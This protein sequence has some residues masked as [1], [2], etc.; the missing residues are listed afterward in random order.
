MF[1]IKVFILYF[2]LVTLVFASQKLKAGEDNL[3]FPATNNTQIMS[4][5]PETGNFTKEIPIINTFLD[6]GLN[7]NY[8]VYLSD[9]GQL[10]VP[11]IV[12]IGSGNKHL[13]GFVRDVNGGVNTLSAGANGGSAVSNTHFYGTVNA[14]GVSSIYSSDGV[15]YTGDAFHGH[16]GYI[17]SSHKKSNVKFLYSDAKYMIEPHTSEKLCDYG[18]TGLYVT[19]ISLSNGYEI[20]FNVN[21]TRVYDDI[22]G[23]QFYK[24]TVVYYTKISDNQRRVWTFGRNSGNGFLQNITYPDG[25]QI[26]CLLPDPI[27]TDVNGVVYTHGNLTPN[28]QFPYVN[29]SGAN[30]TQSL[31]ESFSVDSSYTNNTI[32]HMNG[33]VDKYLGYPKHYTISADPGNGT[34]KE[35]KKLDKSG[36]VVYDEVNT[37]NYTANATPYLI[38]QTITQDGVTISKK[39]ADFNAYL[40]PQT[41]T[42]TASDGKARVTKITYLELSSSATHG[43]MV[44][45]KKIQ[46][47]DSGGKVLHII[48]NKYDIEGYL[49]SSTNDGVETKYTYDSNGNLATSTDTRGNTTEYQDYQYG[50]PTVVIDPKG[51]KTVYSYDYRGVVLSKTDPE[52]NTTKYYY[53]ISGRPTLITPPTG[54]SISYAY[55]NNGLTVTKYQGQVATVIN[56]DGFGKVINSTS[57]VR[58][59]SDSVA[60]VYKYDIINNKV[61]TS[62]PCLSINQCAIGDIYTY[63]I[64]GRPIQL[65]K[66]TSSF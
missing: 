47:T 58:G 59:S 18:L 3:S 54:Y 16:E 14:G 11:L 34:Y 52:G 4:Y 55:S 7:F 25:R 30:L 17:Y 32:T 28:R 42:E 43:H 22:R 38:E 66:D 5:Q 53:D 33:S 21:S 50:K 49:I 15:L 27:I 46:V 44:K 9:S 19:K 8:S 31:R 6:D 61:F 57:S 10:S 26:K 20:N 56:Y 39:F 41:I 60:Q 62:Y 45:P 12:T 37:W 23:Q 2:S 35:H 48:I 40:Y 24:C 64:L 51:G 1:I 13:I 63:D 36:N 65:I 29:Y